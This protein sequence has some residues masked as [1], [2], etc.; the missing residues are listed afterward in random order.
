MILRHNQSLR[1]RFQGKLCM[2]LM[3]LRTEEWCHA[4]QKNPVSQSPK[5]RKKVGDVLYLSCVLGSTDYMLFN[6][7]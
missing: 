6:V 3:A 4:E 1:L 2:Q 7:D 5:E